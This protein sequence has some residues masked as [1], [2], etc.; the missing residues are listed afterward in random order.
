MYKVWVLGVGEST[1]ATNGLE[2]NTVDDATKWGNDLLM[3]WFGADR[4]V[5]L[6]VDDKYTGFLDS[7]I[8]VSNAVA[9]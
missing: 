7:T 4:F 1:Y 5:V 6:P 3:R 2:F 9:S 8:A